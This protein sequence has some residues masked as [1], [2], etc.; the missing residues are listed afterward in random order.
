MAEI[1][2]EFSF[3]EYV[4]DDNLS[5]LR[6]MPALLNCSVDIGTRDSLKPRL[7]AQVLA[8]CIDVA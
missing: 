6:W 2:K 8:E 7:R 5:R 1:V 3:S 4:V